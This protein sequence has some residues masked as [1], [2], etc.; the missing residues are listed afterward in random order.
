MLNNSFL[1]IPG[2]GSRTEQRIWASGIG[3]LEEFAAS[4]PAFIGSR[5][6]SHILQHIDL[7]HECILCGRSDYFYSGLGSAHH[8]RLFPEFRDSTAYVDIETTGLGGPGDIITTI[9]LYDGSSV[10]HYVS[11]ENLD[12]F[13][14]DIEKYKV[15][16]TYNGKTFDIPF[17]ER[18]FDIRLPQAH[19]DLRYILNSLGYSGGLKS[20]EKQ[21]GI[22]RTG[23]LAEVDGFFAVLLW[24]EYRVTGN[25]KALDTLLS[26]NI[27]DAVN[28]EY[29]MVWAYN[30][31]LGSIP[32][33]L[34]GLSKPA[35]CVNPFDVDAVTVNR[36][37]QR[38][39]SRGYGWS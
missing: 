16:V 8:W 38:Y 23:D 17:I 24:N 1:H 31:K 13:P 33:D 19:L 15:L 26:Y 5:M 37:R 2:V 18:Y 27:S 39:F 3:S 21:L 36:I 35:G 10:Y 4:P 22:G 34:P 25:R 20:C 14:G 7:S 9:A 29:L 11:G 32:L 6:R 12:E 28:L 30:R